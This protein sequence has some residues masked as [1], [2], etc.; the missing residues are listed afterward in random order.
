MRANRKATLFHRKFERPYDPYPHTFEAE[1]NLETEMDTHGLNARRHPRRRQRDKALV[2]HGLHR[3][4]HPGKPHRPLDE[5]ALE[6]AIARL[7]EPRGFREMTIRAGEW[8][9]THDDS[10]SH[11]GGELTACHVLDVYYDVQYDKTRIA[12]LAYFASDGTEA[13]AWRHDGV[14][15]E[16]HRVLDRIAELAQSHVLN[17]LES[18]SKG[19]DPS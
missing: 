15:D 4:H 10:F 7:F 6:R 3:Q 5:S 11:R 13:S 16:G 12:R 19:G 9:I 17:T 1:R 8:Y 2:R 14:K 18:D